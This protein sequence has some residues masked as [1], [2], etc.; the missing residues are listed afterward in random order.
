V[1]RSDIDFSN[2]T[3][4]LI[5]VEIRVANVSAR[6]SAPTEMLLQAAP[7]GAFVPWQPLAT[8]HV[9]ALRPGQ[10][11]TVRHSARIVRPHPLGTPDRIPPRKLLTALGLAD[12]PPQPADKGQPAL[13]LPGTRIMPAD[14]MQ[15]L[16]QETPHWV[17]NLNVLIGK[18]DVERHLARALRVLPGRVNLAWFMLGSSRRDAYAFHLS[19]VAADWEAKLFDMTSRKTLVLDVAQSP[20][21]APE[22][23]IVGA[24]TRTMLL[25]LRPP[26]ACGTGNIEVHVTQ[27]STGRTAVVEFSLDPNAAG[28]GCY[29]V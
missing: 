26:Q 18:Q 20:S 9:P 23:W 4:N 6:P 10:V 25:A 3:K 29:V 8:L 21:L 27:R 19:G 14:L 7:F 28:R 22:Q 17:G 24:G 11:M 16:M 12:E 1:S 2:G 15:L 5:A 13:S